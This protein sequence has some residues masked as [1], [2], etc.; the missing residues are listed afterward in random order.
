MN[1]P[2]PVLMLLAGCGFAAFGFGQPLGK[3]VISGTV[4]EG[5]SGDGVRKA[6]VTLTLE[7][8]PRRWATA[9]TDGSGRFQFD[10]LPPGKYDL[11]ATKSNEG[12]AV[13]G[14]NHARELGDV[15]TLADGETRAGVQ[16]RMLHQ[17]SISGHVYNAEGEPVTEARVNLLREGRSLGA[18]VPVMQLSAGTDERGE[19][20]IAAV[21]PGRYYLCAIPQRFG[22]FGG[23][24]NARQ[25]MLVS[26]YYGGSQDF[27]DADVVHVRAG[28]NLAGL[29]FR[30]SLE[31]VVDV[32]GQ[33]AGIPDGGNSVEIS[34]TPADPG[35]QMW[36]QATS[37]QG[38]HRFEL[39]PVP[40]GRYRIEAISHYDAK[41][42]SASQVV[43]LRPG[44][45]DILLT[46]TPAMEMQGT[47][48]VEGSGAVRKSKTIQV[49]L[50]RPDRRRD[51]LT[52]EVAADGHF[53]V[54][55]VTAGEW[56]LAVTPLPPGFLKAAQYGEKDVRFTPFEAVA[57]SDAR[58]N[59]VVSMRTGTLEGEV[60]AGSPASD[61]KRAGIVL[62]PQGPY[63]D[64]ARYYYQATSDADGRFRL[65][66]IAP[67][68]YRMFALEK[69]SAAG[70]RNPEATDQLGELGELIDVEEGAQLEVHPRL[71][72]FERAIKALQ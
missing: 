23:R 14:A 65:T 17:A 36:S 60:E 9:R 22:R 28:E 63:H 39:A 8:S 50:S 1:V 19:Y 32:R 57:D 12:T 42:Y 62:A 44:V 67:G 35:P 11:R 71:I 51:R 47:L 52:A 15:I 66:G 24:G 27:K 45:G 55:P 10:G 13:Y 26:Q 49:Q 7:G 41:T 59:I 72:P 70:F 21:E 33:V 64:L 54:G 30:L 31:A 3:G 46:L 56:Q 4:V 5:D 48:R 58:L 37:M 16:L 69:M 6:I 43:D 53:S 18:A 38:G 29:D 20:Q 61:S 25:P 2:G 68:K 34:I 40:A